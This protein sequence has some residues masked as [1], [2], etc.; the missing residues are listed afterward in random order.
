[1]T[2]IKKC[3]VVEQYKLSVSLDTILNKEKFS[4]EQVDN[5][6]LNQVTLTSLVQDE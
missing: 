3:F 6:L 4:W 1:M 5:H 2:I